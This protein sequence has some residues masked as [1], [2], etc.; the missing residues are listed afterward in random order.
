MRDIQII[1]NKHNSRSIR[2]KVKIKDTTCFC[3][4]FPI[5][6]NLKKCKGHTYFFP[7]KKTAESFAT[8]EL[9]NEKHMSLY[10]G[11]YFSKKLKK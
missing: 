4:D 10:L 6:G 7:T 1:H 3:G 5:F 9:K 2:W 11:F 8:K